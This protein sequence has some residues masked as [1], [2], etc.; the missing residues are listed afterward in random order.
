MLP[1]KVDLASNSPISAVSSL[2]PP[3]TIADPRQD[4][5]FK[6]DQIAIGKTLQGQVLAKLTDGNSLIRIQNNTQQ[7]APNTDIKMLLPKGFQ[8]GDAVQLTVLSSGQRP[9]FTV[10]LLTSADTVTLSNAAQLIDKALNNNRQDEQNAPRITGASPLLDSVNTDPTA[11][12]AQLHKSVDNSGVFYEAHL[13]Q[14]AEGKRN[15]AQI[16]QE[17]Q[18]LPDPE[19]T[20]TSITDQPTHWLSFQLDTLENRRFAWQGE[21]WPG[22][23]FQ[24][25]ISKDPDH[26]AAIP[27]T[28]QD[29]I[30]QTVVR[31]QLAN[32]GQINATIRLQGEHVQVQ[33]N[34][35]NQAT[36]DSLKNA[37]G[38]L[39]L[40]LAASGTALDNI[41]IQDHEA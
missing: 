16:H 38:Q 7:S 37:I 19:K 6:L 22:Q 4:G 11:M 18:N 2:R 13:R 24:W 3:E 27:E 1:P 29:P 26:Q 30:W 21:L 8:I 23:S 39:I 33:V 32:L 20:T 15:L 31:F 41:T 25:E 5:I 17:P 10:S 35:Q 9:T 34:V 28:N 40:A 36:T 14:W 12:A